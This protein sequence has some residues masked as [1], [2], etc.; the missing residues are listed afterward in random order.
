MRIAQE[1]C[2]QQTRFPILQRGAVIE[3][4]WRMFSEIL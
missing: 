4:L 2:Q 3:K 1:V